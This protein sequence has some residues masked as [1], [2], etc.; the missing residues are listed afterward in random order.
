YP[1]FIANP[2]NEEGLPREWNAKQVIRS[3]LQITSSIYYNSIDIPSCASSIPFNEDKIPEGAK[4]YWYCQMCD[5]TFSLTKKQILKH[6]SECNGDENRV[7]E[8]D[9]VAAGTTNRLVK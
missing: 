9:T 7:I 2:N 6:V 4:L 3:G 8:E 5:S 1:K